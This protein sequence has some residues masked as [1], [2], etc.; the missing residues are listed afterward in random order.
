M[1]LAPARAGENDAH[2]YFFDIAGLP[3]PVDAVEV[4]VGRPGIPARLVKVTPITADHVSLYSVALP[5]AGR[6]TFHITTVRNGQPS[7]VNIEVPI[8]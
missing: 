5:T 4:K 1:E 6:W 3:R 7:V 8:R 2:L